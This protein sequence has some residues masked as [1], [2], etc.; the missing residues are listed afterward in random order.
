MPVDAIET[1]IA[2]AL[3]VSPFTRAIWRRL[4]PAGVLSY[5]AG[6]L[7]DP[8]F[9]FAELVVLVTAAERAGQLEDAGRLV[10]ARRFARRAA[11]G[12]SA[13]AGGSVTWPR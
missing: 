13:R 7:A 12:P 3:Y 9:R 11:A 8:R 1:T 4:G 6:L 10:A 5:A 2:V